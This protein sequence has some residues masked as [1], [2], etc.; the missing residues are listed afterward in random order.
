MQLNIS[1]KAIFSVILTAVISYF[2]MLFVTGKACL[3]DGGCTCTCTAITY[4]WLIVLI[5]SL[6]SMSLV[7]GI[8]SLIKKK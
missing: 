3:F 2:V 5:A 1:M 4:S 6:L 8:A 7:Y